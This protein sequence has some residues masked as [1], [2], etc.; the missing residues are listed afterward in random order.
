MM[1]FR[2]LAEESGPEQPVYAMQI[3]DDDV[4]KEMDS[5]NMEMLAHLNIRLIRK[6]QSSGPYRLG[7]W[8]LWGWMAYEVARLLEEQGEVVE[9]LVIIDVVAPGF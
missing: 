4:P 1:I 2:N 7:G 6:L 3:M 8:C 9:L 5:A